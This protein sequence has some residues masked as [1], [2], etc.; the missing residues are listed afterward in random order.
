MQF[1]EQATTLV[2]G[3]GLARPDSGTLIEAVALEAIE[4][5]QTSC[6]AGERR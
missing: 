3:V 4:A 1:R 6:R 2:K 5:S